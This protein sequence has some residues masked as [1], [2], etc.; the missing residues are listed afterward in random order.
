MQM[1]MANAIFWAKDQW[2]ASQDRWSAIFLARSQAS[3][4]Y[5]CSDT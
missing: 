5:Y 3:A 4:V 1:L 2:Y